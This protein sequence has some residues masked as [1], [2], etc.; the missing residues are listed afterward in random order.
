V[1]PALTRV[2]LRPCAATCQ[3]QGHPQG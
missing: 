2:L 3:E 1:P